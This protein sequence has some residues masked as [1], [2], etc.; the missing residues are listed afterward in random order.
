MA[1]LRIAVGLLTFVNGLL[2][3]PD[4]LAWFG[5]EGAT[6]WDLVS[7]GTPTLSQITLRYLPTQDWIYSGILAII[8]VGSLMVT[9]GYK[10][11]VS[12]FLTWL[13][14]LLLYHRNPFYF[15]HVDVLV[16]AYLFC[17]LLSPCA[18]HYSL[19]SKGRPQPSDKPPFAQRMVQVQVCLIYLEGVFGKLLQP[20][21]LNGTAVYYALHFPDG[22]H[23]LVP[24]WM[25]HLW[26]YQFLTYSTLLI[27][28]SLA[29]GLWV[30]GLRPVLIP[31]G[32]LFHLGIQYFLNLDLLEFGMI[33]GYLAFTEGSAK[34]VWD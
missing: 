19:D 25:D 1:K 11:R 34:G 31:V 29:L 24:A 30:R 21:W 15:H 10:T 3:L 14:Q 23:H 16:R 20:E 22:M 5:S 9:V 4:F 33:V 13:A 26:C 12:L 18:D 32:I 7:Q 28:A 17:L 8:L 27:E 6:P 2:Y